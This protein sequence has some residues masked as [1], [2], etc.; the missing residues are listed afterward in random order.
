MQSFEEG[1]EL[2]AEKFIHVV[3][4]IH[5]AKYS[6][7][8][9]GIIDHIS[10][11]FFLHLQYANKT[12]VFVIVS[13]LKSDLITPFLGSRLNRLKRIFRKVKISTLCC[14]SPDFHTS[15]SLPDVSHPLLK[16]LRTLPPVTM[17]KQTQ[18]SEVEH[19]LKNISQVNY[20]IQHF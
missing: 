14:N 12:K 18:I 3:D 4:S 16:V 2:L 15:H 7:L 10:N 19:F 20:Q 13:S 9:A 17:V 1:K 8:R 6:T 5:S 11:F